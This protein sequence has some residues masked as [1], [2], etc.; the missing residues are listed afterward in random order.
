MNIRI[1]NNLPEADR[2]I[3]IR[4]AC[5]QLGNELYDI[6][7]KS[8]NIDL[9]TKSKLTKKICAEY[10]RQGIQSMLGVFAQADIK[11][12]YDENNAISLA[13]VISKM[14]K[15]NYDEL[16]YQIDQFN[17]NLEDTIEKERSKESKTEPKN[18]M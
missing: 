9:E 13:N 17:I 3:T 18:E 8:E 16:I 5:N 11:I 14:S 1:Y 4:D 6:C 2:L 12:E 15:E 7:Q 10:A